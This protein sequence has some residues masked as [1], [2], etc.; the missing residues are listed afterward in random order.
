R[1]EPPSIV[2]SLE[3]ANEI[4]LYSSKLYVLGGNSDECKEEID[5]NSKTELKNY[6]KNRVDEYD[7]ELVARDS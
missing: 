7:N 3:N 6:F 4:K 1:R 2:D 5:N